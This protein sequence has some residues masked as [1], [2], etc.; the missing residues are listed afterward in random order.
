MKI[1][2]LL[3]LFCFQLLTGFGFA[4]KFS[5]TGG[6]KDSTGKSL[7][8]A[9][10]GLYKSKDLNQPVKITYTT[11]KGKFNFNNIDTGNYTLI[12]THTGFAESK[13]DIT[14]SNQNIELNDIRLT[15]A[16][17]QLQGVNVTVKKPL[18]EQTDDKIIFN[19]ENDPTTKTENAIDILRKTPFVTV[20]G[21]NNVMVNGQSNFKVLLNGRET[22][23]FAQNVKEALR[24]FPGALITKIEIITSPSAKYDG[25]GI[26]GIINIITKKKVI[27]YNGS[28][29]TYYSTSGWKNLN[30]NF[31]A[32]FG[33]LGATAYFGMGGSNNVKGS[34]STE[35]LPFTPT[36]FTR[37]FLLGD[38][39]SGNMW[40]FGNAELSYEIDSLNTLSAYG[41]VNGGWN[42]SITH[43]VS[44][45]DFTTGASSVSQYNLNNR[46]EYPTNSIGLDYI[47]KYK[48]NNEK[49]FSIRLNDE[50][51][52]VNTFLNSEQDNPVGFNDRFIINN[53]VA[54]NNQYTIQSDLIQPL[55]NNRKIEMGVK[56]IFRRAHSDF[57][58]QIKYDPAENFKVNTGNTDHFNYEQDIYSAYSTYSFKVKKV[59]FRLGARVEHTEVNGDFTSS[60]TRVKQNYTTL[61]PNLQATIKPGNA[62]TWVLNYNVRLQRPSIYSLNPFVENNDSLNILF[63]NPDLNAQTIHSVSVQT[64]VMKGATFVGLTLNSSYSDNLIVR[65]ST[66]DPVTGITSTTRGNYGKEVRI[67]LNGNVNIK[68]NDNWNLSVNGNVTY[69]HVTNKFNHNQTNGGVGGNANMNTSYKLNSRFNINSYAGF[70][71][72]PVG[73]QSTQSIQ[74]WYGTGLG[75]KMFSEKLTLTVGLANFLQKDNSY[76]YIINDP[77]FRTTNVSTSPYRGL[78]VGLSWNFGKLTENV[79]KKKGVSNDDLIG[80]NTGG[81]R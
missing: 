40:N 64:R 33:K 57:V 55:S 44:T 41:N 56:G 45:T 17:A 13:Q 9:T 4:Q 69:N 71:R 6:L 18:V 35:T 74:V 51:G 75:Y 61:L 36:I 78:S 7:A 19:V 66:F 23:M 29:N 67:G 15:S 49:E 22:S 42:K 80:G 3:L 60:S 53:S 34:S 14:I 21:D 52:G 26:G 73:I 32:K 46:Q 70:W 48:N 8:Y 27:G 31:S 1:Y 30:S 47:K 72:S 28:I 77:A 39:V 24:G 43:Q 76:T 63:G 2:K 12:F 10:A 5:V 68:F 20:D 38:Q 65:Y 11:E 62:F 81:G 59:T 54:K 79:S 50:F 58:S 37:R 16:V 25:E